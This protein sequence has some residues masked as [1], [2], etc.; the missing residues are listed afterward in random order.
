MRYS[1]LIIMAFP[2]LTLAFS[3]SDKLTDLKQ[4]YEDEIRTE[5][6]YFM[7]LENMFE[8]EKTLA[9]AKA[10]KSGNLRRIDI[11]IE[12]GVDINQLGTKNATVLLYSIPNEQGF[13]HLLINGANP[14]VLFDSGGSVV[15]AAA[16]MDNIFFLTKALEHGGDANLRSLT[17][18]RSPLF[19]AV[20]K[21]NV[22][23]IQLLVK[24]GADMSLYENDRPAGIYGLSPLSSALYGQRYDSMLTLLRLGADFNQVEK[25]KGQT[26]LDA[27]KNIASRLEKPSGQ[28]I[29]IIEWMESKNHEMDKEV[30]QN[31]E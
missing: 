28:L 15:H 23:A 30:Q 11:L 27:A 13:N 21:N 2:L 29:N 7:P 24:N 20:M 31:R 1:I 18:G 14:N 17:S 5:N 8:D 4:Q 22:A 12:Q 16:S 26:I 3:S 25:N 9:L 19:N 6:V 10:A